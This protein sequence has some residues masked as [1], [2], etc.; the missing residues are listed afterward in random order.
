MPIDLR[1]FGV[2]HR[3]PD[4]PPGT[5]GIE[6]QVIESGAGGVIAELAFGLHARITPH[7]N[8]NWSCFVVIEGGGWAG[9][10]DER[11]RV[12]A[13]EA[14]V[15][16]PDVLHAAWTDGT[17]MRAIVVEFAG[18]QLALPPVLDGTTFKLVADNAPVARGEGSLAPR[19][20]D[21]SHR[22]EDPEAE[23]GEPL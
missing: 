23:E 19:P 5:T 8:P 13:G 11:T 12:Q 1:R 7:T 16:P 15:W 22:G 9:V 14:V 4:G 10:G 6:G 21:A 17:Q 18:P 20:V 2:G 3:R